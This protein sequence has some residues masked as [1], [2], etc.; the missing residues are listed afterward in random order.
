[1]R[2]DTIRIF[3]VNSLKG[4][5]E[6]DFQKEPLKSSGLFAITG[7]TGSGKSTILDVIM[8]GLYNYI[9]RLEGI[10][11]TNK[12]E[13]LGTIVTHYCTEAWVEIEY[14]CRVGRF[15]SRWSIQKKKRAKGFGDYQMDL[16]ELPYDKSLGLKKSEV[17]IANS[18]N[19]GLNAKQF[20]KTI[21]LSQGDFARFLK[22][23]K[24][25]RTNLLEEITGAKI[26]R[27]IG[28]RAYQLK[29]DIDG[30]IKDYNTKLSTIELLSEEEILTLN[31][32]Q[33]NTNEALSHLKSSIKTLHVVRDLKKLQENIKQQEKSINEKK[34]LISHKT[35]IYKERS[36][37]LHNHEKV[38]AH[39]S[40]I[41]KIIELEKSIKTLESG[42]SNLSNAIDSDNKQ[43]ISSIKDASTLT[44]KTVDKESILSELSSF[45]SIIIEKDQSLNQLS[46]QGKRIRHEI[47]SKLS[48]ANYTFQEEQ[49]KIDPSLAIDLLNKKKSTFNTPSNQSRTDL[50]NSWE[51]INNK[52]DKTKDF[53]RLT[54]EHTTLSNEIKTNENT[55]TGLGKSLEKEKDLLQ[56]I[57][58]KIKS[59]K[60]VLTETKAKQKQLL[61]KG[62]W[63]AELEKLSE[64][65]PCPICGSTDHPYAIHKELT[66][67]TILANKIIRIESDIEEQEKLEKQYKE[68]LNKINVSIDRYEDVNLKTQAKQLDID[69]VI[70]KMTTDFSYLKKG[71]AHE[72]DIEKYNSDLSQIKKT[73]KQLDEIKIIEELLISYTSLEN[74]INEYRSIFTARKNLY[75]GSDITTDIDLIQDKY[76]SANERISLNLKTLES[77]R[78]LLNNRKIEKQENLKLIEPVSKDMNADKVEHLL[79][80]KLSESELNTITSLKDEITS[81]K[82]SIETE[83]ERLSKDIQRF[84]DEQSTVDKSNVSFLEKELTVL[85]EELIILEKQEAEANK[86]IGKIR[87]IL[88]TNTETLTKQKRFID[89]QESLK[90]KARKYFILSDMIGD[91]EGKKWAAYAQNLTFMHLISRANAR[92]ESLTD[93]YL[94]YFDPE[95]E[96][97]IV[98]DKYAGD[99]LR[100]VDT[101]SGG[102]TF[103]FSLAL[104]LSLSDFT[105]NNISIESLF[106]DEGFATLDNQTLDDVMTTLEKLQDQSGKIIGIIS[107]IES[108]KDRINT[109]IKVH[110]TTDGYSTI[111]IV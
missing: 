68:N 72:R 58:A 88:T 7:P 74:T 60:E 70:E 87:Q 92:L 77:N 23:N 13:K 9:P 21:L 36:L 4:L 25:E 105:S 44:H 2:I 14:T 40:S 48:L 96:S 17:P 73:L 65:D 102:E 19:I 106:I 20:L 28:R 76:N 49:E 79:S 62:K 86:K 46:I 56:P 45:R 103:L 42:I 100:S 80:F 75:A 38:S 29:T 67:I 52:I 90:N 107:H 82:S 93:R 89:E 34:E 32:D 110:K 24:E 22:A 27:E 30:Q 71:H 66:D 54:K 33:S 8:L 15:R 18:S 94:F 43:I 50:Q 95:E 111:D 81:L 26:Y 104:A 59:F 41:H 47:N 99:T 63:K 39:L 85:N 57:P 78:A 69:S 61:E 10:I 6:I 35:K 97:L 51:L 101:L 11:S 5:H 1:M 109:Q 84:S 53:I 3:N 91:R 16:I 108:L 37:K 83:K 55:L 64:G 31:Q 98:V 12:I